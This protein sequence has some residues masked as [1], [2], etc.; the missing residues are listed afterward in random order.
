[1]HGLKTWRVYCEDE[2]AHFEVE[3]DT[4]PTECPN[5]GGHTITPAK[6][7][8]L[9]G[10]AHPFTK[11]SDKLDTTDATPGVFLEIPIPDDSIVMVEACV[12]AFRTNG[13]DYAAYIVR[14]A[15]RRRSG[16]NATILGSVDPVFT[17][18]SDGTWACTIDVSGTTA[19]VLV[20]GAGSKDITWIGR[21]SFCNY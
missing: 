21:Y 7:C 9:I 17:E 10:S 5:D 11:I 2:V 13:E 1:M 8:V 4:E 3:S 20:T 12:T 15:V 19:Q 18:E 14:A 6:T 16:G